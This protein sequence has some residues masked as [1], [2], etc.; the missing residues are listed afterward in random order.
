MCE[1]FRL[2]VTN[3]W[4]L[5]NE[6]RPPGLV[7]F[8]TSSAKHR[9]QQPSEIRTL[10]RRSGGGGRRRRGKWTSSARS[11]GVR[12]RNC[13]WN[14]QNC[15][16]NTTS[17]RAIWWVPAVPFYFVSSSTMAETL[18]ISHVLSIAP[19][20]TLRG[21]NADFTQNM[22]NIST[23]YVISLLY[24]WYHISYLWYHCNICDIIVLSLISL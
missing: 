1:I 10:T 24:K 8:K 16:K 20:T 2:L 6:D 3:G 21:E 4:T 12:R 7:S 18:Q 17:W 15:P 23:F 11:P 5:R 19:F 13:R 22:S 14:L 9:T